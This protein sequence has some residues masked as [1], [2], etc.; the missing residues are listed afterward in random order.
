MPFPLYFYNSKSLS[1]CHTRV[2][3][4]YAQG[5]TAHPS[6]GKFQELRKCEKPHKDSR[7]AAWCPVFAKDLNTST[8]VALLPVT[9]VVEA[10]LLSYH[11]RH[12]IDQAVVR[13][14]NPVPGP[15]VSSRASLISSGTL[16]EIVVALGLSSTVELMF[17]SA[18]KGCNSQVLLSGSCTEDRYFFAGWFGGMIYVLSGHSTIQIRVALW[19]FLTRDSRNGA[20]GC[21]VGWRAGSRGRACVPRHYYENWETRFRGSDKLL[22]RPE[23]CSWGDWHQ[24]SS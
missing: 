10:I 22:L 17:L 8:R 9:L 11:N 16:S 14:R 7:G 1:V 18:S 4:E 2:S 21:M 24:S 3:K 15:I 23:A 20:D 12:T 19:S 6:R 13:G 5:P